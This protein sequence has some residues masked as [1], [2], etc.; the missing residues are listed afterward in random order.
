MRSTCLLTAALV[1][2]TA[3]PS[4]ALADVLLLADGSY[5][6]GKVLSESVTEITIETSGKVARKVTIKKS[7][8]KRRVPD[9]GTTVRPTTP[10]PGSTIDPTKLSGQVLFL[11]DISGSMAIGERYPLAERWLKELVQK[12]APD[13]RFNVLLFSDKTSLLFGREYLP[14]SARVKK[15]LATYLKR[16]M[17]KGIDRTRFTDLH[18]AMK[19]ALDH[20]GT[21]TVIVLSDGVPTAGKI[22]NPETLLSWIE[23]YRTR[24]DAVGKAKT[25]PRIHVRSLL[26]GHAKR[27]QAGE[28]KE[29]ARTFLRLLAQK[30]G[31]SYGEVTGK[32][33]LDS[34]F[35]RP[36][37]PRGP[38]IQ[39]QYYKSRQVIHSIRLAAKGFY[40]AFH[41]RVIDPALAH[42]DYRIREY[43]LDLKLVVESWDR[44]GEIEVDSPTA[45]PLARNG[46]SV[47]STKYLRVTGPIDNQEA[48]GSHLDKRVYLKAFTGGYLKI[49]YT[50]EGRTFQKVV[51]I[52]STD[53][54]EGD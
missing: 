34:P 40:P 38:E 21:K 26:G 5:V 43:P 12:L 25:P 29:A 36:G 1:L 6:E 32:L 9:S 53:P 18:Q 24:A 48:H 28:D 50:R 31:G 51:K 37:K 49:K 10:G 42:G 8:I 27:S 14:A 33:K 46:T 15:R 39:V 17:K 11:L 20:V 41:L 52:S 30:S 19:L 7:D 16:R 44:G 13:V 45:I 23:G 54:N 47:W 22:K 4:V 2:V 35:K 3:V